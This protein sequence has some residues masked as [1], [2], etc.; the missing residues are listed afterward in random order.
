MYILYIILIYNFLAYLVLDNEKT[1]KSQNNLTKNNSSISL[2]NFV[3]PDKKSL[4]L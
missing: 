3:S 2:N 1:I 4:P